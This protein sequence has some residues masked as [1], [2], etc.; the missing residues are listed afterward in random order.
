MLCVH[1]A[2]QSWH[3]M[4]GALLGL[5]H[6]YTLRPVKQLKDCGPST[7]ALLS[8]SLM[9][10]KIMH[11]IHLL[12]GIQQKAQL[13]ACAGSQ[14]APHLQPVAPLGLGALHAALSDGG[15]CKSL[16]TKG[17]LATGFLQG[18]SS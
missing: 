4:L 11:V 8:K 18:L 6:I 16:A 1:N 14:A 17:L 12:F 10:T 2:Q 13:N 5:Q 15:Q 7:Q 3:I 9:I